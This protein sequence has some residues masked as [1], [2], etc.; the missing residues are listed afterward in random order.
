M[1]KVR[2]S[3]A[4]RLAFGYT[5]LCALAVLV[6]GLGVYYAASALLRQD[7]DRA[8][9]QE[10]ASLE[11]E[12]GEGGRPDLI[13]ALTRHTGRTGNGFRYAL[14]DPAGQPGHRAPEVVAQ[15]TF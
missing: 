8:I 9:V 13:D 4:Y 7:F 15:N 2:R 10:M 6:T 12:Y 1:P 11:R 3:A 14:F 5:A